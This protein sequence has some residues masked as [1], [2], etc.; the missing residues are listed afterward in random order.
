MATRILAGSALV[1]QLGLHW[2]A[3][4][5]GSTLS[6]YDLAKAL[7]HGVFVPHA[8][9]YFG[10]LIYVA[11]IVGIVVMITSNGGAQW[12]FLRCASSGALVTAFATL[13]VVGE[14]AL[15]DWGPGL[16]LATAASGTLMIEAI[17]NKRP[18]GPDKRG[19]L[20]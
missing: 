13:A 17:F 8:A 16:V 7:R 1:G 19:Q 14:P 5:N 9:R 10:L 12:R 20:R 11:A 4:G 18:T 3:S 15:R 2:T 6:G